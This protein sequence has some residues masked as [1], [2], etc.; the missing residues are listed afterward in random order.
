MSLEV[1]IVAKK[2]AQNSQKQI[3]SKIL[4]FGEE[5]CV[6]SL[7]I[8]DILKLESNENICGVHKVALC[9]CGQSKGYPLC[10]KTHQVFNMETNS[11]LSPLMLNLDDFAKEAI[12]SESIKRKLRKSVHLENRNSAETKEVLIEEKIPKKSKVLFKSKINS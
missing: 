3:K 8:E 1:N 7:D 6:G 10:D 2:I 12:E 9:R 11:T 4:A 5:K